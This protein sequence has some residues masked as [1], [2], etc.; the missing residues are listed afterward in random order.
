MSIAAAKDWD[1]KL[2]LDEYSIR[3]IYFWRDNLERA[4]LRDINHNPTQ[5][6]YVVY[7]DAGASGCGVH[8][9]LCGDQIR[10]KQ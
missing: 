3:E 10:H 7:S 6:H 2:T 9:N 8:V 4:N 1:S 5:L